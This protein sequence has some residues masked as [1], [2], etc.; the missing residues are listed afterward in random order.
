MVSGNC[1][2]VYSTRVAC[3]YNNKKEEMSEA[4]LHKN[5]FRLKVVKINGTRGYNSHEINGPGVNILQIDNQKDENHKNYR[6]VFN[7]VN[8]KFQRNEKNVTRKH[9]I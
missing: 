7:L 1:I 8:S 6:N 4:C 2:R 9:R 5:H 3:S